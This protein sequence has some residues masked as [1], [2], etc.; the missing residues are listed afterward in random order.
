MREQTY[1]TFWRRAPSLLACQNVPQLMVKLHV[2][3]RVELFVWERGGQGCKEAAS[4]VCLAATL[5]H[6]PEQ[7]RQAT[8]VQSGRCALWS[9]TARDGA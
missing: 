6:V 9:R 8:K 2:S 5:V 1:A 7:Q 3:P 4:G